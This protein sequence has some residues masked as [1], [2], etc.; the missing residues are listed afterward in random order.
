MAALLAGAGGGGVL[1]GIIKLLGKL[2]RD[3]QVQ[4]LVAKAAKE[5]LG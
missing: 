2:A 5:K 3:K 1:F 4:E